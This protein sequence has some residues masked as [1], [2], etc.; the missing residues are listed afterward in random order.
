M[1]RFKLESLLN[2]RKY[3]EDARQKELA[4]VNRLLQKEKNRLLEFQRKEKVCRERLVNKQKEPHS[5]SEILICRNYLVKISTEIE[6]QKQVILKVQEEQDLKRQGLVAAM[7]KRKTLDKLKDKA[8]R[9]YMKKEL[10]K[11]QDF[12]NEVAGNRFHRKKDSLNGEPGQAGK[13]RK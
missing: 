11:E 5:P 6:N 13:N 1:F 2:H 12:M 9:Q 3:L 7:K 8:F 10:K 4:S